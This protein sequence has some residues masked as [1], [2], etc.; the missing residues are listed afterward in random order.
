MPTSQSQANGHKRSVR[1]N[2]KTESAASSQAK[3]R[4]QSEPHTQRSRSVA[5]AAAEAVLHAGSLKSKTRGALEE[6]RRQ[7]TGRVHKVRD[8][9]LSASQLVRSEHEAVSRY[10]ERAGKKVE[11][12]ASYIGNADLRSLRSDAERMARA[13]PGWFVGGAL[14]TGFVLGRLFKAAGPLALPASTGSQGENR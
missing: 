5:G 14:V 13:N 11:D 9:L 10:L 7:V 12:V 2:G 8:V 6:Q 4:R 1:S 3:P